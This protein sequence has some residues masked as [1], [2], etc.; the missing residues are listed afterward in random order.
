M[1]SLILWVCNLYILFVLI[2]RHYLICTIN[3]YECRA[4]AH[5]RQW[6]GA[7][8][9]NSITVA[10]RKLSQN[11]AYACNYAKFWENMWVCVAWG[12]GTRTIVWCYGYVSVQVRIWL[13]QCTYNMMCCSVLHLISYIHVFISFATNIYF[14]HIGCQI[15][16]DLWLGERSWER[17]A[18]ERYR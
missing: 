6:L 14:L 1:E 17:K 2:T 12:S 18:W 11:F 13:F 9:P 10:L 8:Y 15:Q 16:R 3:I 5:L 7:V 4:G